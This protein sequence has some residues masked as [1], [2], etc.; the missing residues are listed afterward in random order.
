[1]NLLVLVVQLIVLSEDIRSRPTPAGS[2]GLDKFV[3]LNDDVRRELMHLYP[4]FMWNFH[5]D[6]MWRHPKPSSEEI[7]K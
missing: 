4:E 6:R 7:F 5:K 2:N 1:M 3:D